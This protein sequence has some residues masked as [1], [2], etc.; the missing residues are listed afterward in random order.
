MPAFDWREH[1]KKNLSQDIS[2][3]TPFLENTEF[4]STPGN[5]ATLHTL[6]YIAG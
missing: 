5:E 2:N 3:D 1:H 4:L 6:A